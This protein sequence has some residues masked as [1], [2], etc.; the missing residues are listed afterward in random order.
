MDDEAPPA[1]QSPAP[2]LAGSVGAL[3]AALVGAALDVAGLAAVMTDAALDPP[4]PVIRYANARFEAITGYAAG[5]LI[6]RSPRLLQGPRTDRAELDRLR[7]SLSAGRHFTGATINYRKDGTPYRNEW[8]VGPVLGPD[9]AVTH[10]LSIQRDATADP[11]PHPRAGLLRDRTAAMLETIRAIATRTLVAP[12]DGR[13]FDGRLAALGRAQG[14]GGS[15]LDTLLRGELDARSIEARLEGPPVPLRPGIAEPLAL[16]LHELATAVPPGG[17]L[18]VAWDLEKGPEHRLLLDWRQEGA[19]A[20]PLPG[21][22]V[23]EEVM[24]F[25][26]G[27]ETRLH[28]EPDGLSCAIALPLGG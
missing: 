13:A 27:G 28:R 24:R 14:A 9:G 26:L 11:R 1:A 10:W 6:G 21:W 4:G 25:A 15:A 19:P 2:D 20:S 23:I 12:E 8:I 3:S 5:E 7:A 17:R 22:P 16:A 18:R